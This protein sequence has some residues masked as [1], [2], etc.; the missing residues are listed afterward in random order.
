MLGSLSTKLRVLGF[1]TLYDRESSDRKLLE[2]AGESGR[3]LLTSDHELFLTAKRS[4]LACVGLHERTEA[5]RLVELFSQ[6]GITEID[7]GRSSRCSLCNGE[8]QGKK[9]DKLGRKVYQCKACRKRYWRGAHW[10]K[11]EALFGE[12]NV[13]LSNSEIN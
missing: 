1:D 9:I 2:I 12:V 3:I 13:S 5:T 4:R 10:Q 7:S 8:L 11:L 6:L